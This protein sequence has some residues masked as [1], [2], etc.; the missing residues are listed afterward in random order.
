MKFSDIPVAAKARIK[1]SE[2]A[3][4]RTLPDARLQV[5]PLPTV[6]QIQLALINADYQTGPL[7][8]DVMRLSSR[9]RPIGHFAGEAALP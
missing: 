4:Q 3:L 6:E 2:Q 9:G 1:S 7:P 5:T 8:A